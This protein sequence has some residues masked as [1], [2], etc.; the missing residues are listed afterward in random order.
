MRTSYATIVPWV[1][2]VAPQPFDGA[3]VVRVHPHGVGGGWSDGT[4]V[5]AAR[6]GRVVPAT[7]A[8]QHLYRVVGLVEPHACDLDPIVEERS[9]RAERAL[10]PSLLQRLVAPDQDDAT[11]GAYTPGPVPGC[12][13]GLDRHPLERRSPRLDPRTGGV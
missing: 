3:R 7:D 12:E 4:V 6:G 9:G 10:A 1:G 8:A 13:H 2:A 11:H 5:E